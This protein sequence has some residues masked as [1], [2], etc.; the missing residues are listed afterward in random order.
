MYDEAITAKLSAPARARYPPLL[1]LT[2]MKKERIYQQERVYKAES[3][4][5]PIL[6]LHQE[7]KKTVNQPNP[8][9]ESSFNYRLIQ[10][11]AIVK[12]TKILQPIINKN[13][14]EYVAL[15]Q[16]Y[17]YLKQKPPQVDYLLSSE[18]KLRI[19]M[20]DAVWKLDERMLEIKLPLDSFT[21]VPSRYPRV[22]DA[23]LTLTQ[24]AVTYPEYSELAKKILTD[25]Q[26]AL[27]HGVYFAKDTQQKNRSYVH[28]FFHE[29]IAR[30]LVNPCHGYSR[31]LPDTIDNCK[32]TYTA[33]IYMQ[34]CRH[35]DGKKWAISYE[36]LR[37]LLNIDDLPIKVD[38]A[39]MKRVRQPQTAS[40]YYEF[41]RRV[42][43]TARDELMAMVS[44]GLTNYYFTY[45]EEFASSKYSTPNQLIFNIYETHPAKDDLSNYD[46]HLKTMRHYAQNILHIGKDRVD[47][48][49]R[50]ITIRNYTY[51]Y[52]RHLA[53]WAYISDREKT[54]NKIDAYYL[55]SILNAIKEE[56]TA[57][58]QGVVQMTLTYQ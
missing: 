17:Y 57:Q 3:V 7:I 13:I 53:I 34:I 19:Q 43:D 18:K 25:G 10:L 51:V 2:I 26:R 47:R 35:A 36:K 31:L 4:T 11:S 24:I 38:K 28:L 15:H 5:L 40:R 54:I 39:S 23:L 44:Q 20:P 46:K 41:R 16:Q 22:R 27:C 33:K 14:D 37:L 55:K 42:L 58:E 30:L 9:L 12:I 52:Q 29:D 8:I 45:I 1:F 48:V 50:Y 6:P 56:R 32:S 49:F 21:E